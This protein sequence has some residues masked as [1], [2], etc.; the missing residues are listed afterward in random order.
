VSG[1]QLEDLVVGA[2]DTGSGRLRLLGSKSLVTWTS[3]RD[4]YESIS[5]TRRAR[6]WLVWIEIGGR[7]HRN[8]EMLL[9][10]AGW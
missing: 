3:L 2:R 7:G 4:A 6:F 10:H 8:G 9:L 5:M 1:P